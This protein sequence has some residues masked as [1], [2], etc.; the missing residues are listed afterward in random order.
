MTVASCSSEI[1][2]DNAATTQIDAEA[3]ALMIDLQK[4]FFANPS[5]IYKLARLPKKFCGSRVKKSLHVSTLNRT[6]F[7]L[8]RAA[9]RAIIGR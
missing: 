5:A 8:H 7:F 6:K 9:R 2:A 4:K 1:Y 3:L